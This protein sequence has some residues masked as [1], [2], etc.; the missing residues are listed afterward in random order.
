MGRKQFQLLSFTLRV[1]HLHAF[2]PTCLR[3]SVQLPQVAQRPLARTARPS[4]RLYQRPV[5][6][7]LTVL[8][9][10]M[11]PQ[12]HLPRSLSSAGFGCKRVGLH[13]IVFLN[14]RL[15]KQD[16]SRFRHQNPQNL[17]LSR[18]TSV[19]NIYLHTTWRLS[20][21][22]IRRISIRR[23][24][25]DFRLRPTTMECTRQHRMAQPGC[26][27]VCIL[28]CAQLVEYILSRKT[29][30]LRL[31]EDSFEHSPRNVSDS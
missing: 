12:K 9:A 11:L 5:G 13:Y 16:L 21:S 24:E 15:Q 6:V 18:R 27:L 10:L 4:H 3:G 22:I 1:E 30:A 17:A 31:R 25:K 7:I 29:K 19:N 20:T 2:K 26:D 23:L 8:A 28:N 14:P